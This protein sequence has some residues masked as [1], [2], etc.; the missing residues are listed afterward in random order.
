M[1]RRNGIIERARKKNQEERLRIL[2]ILCLRDKSLRKCWLEFAARNFTINPI[3][4]YRSHHST[5]LVTPVLLLRPS[6]FVL[7]PLIA[8]LLFPRVILTVGLCN[9][10]NTHLL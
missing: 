2:K 4:R 6:S 3:K 5:I 10:Y 9:I 8:S 1:G 7:V